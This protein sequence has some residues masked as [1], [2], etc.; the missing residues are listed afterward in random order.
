MTT[1]TESTDTKEAEKA[2]KAK[3]KAV[4]LL[5]KERESLMQ[6]L[7]TAIVAEAWAKQAATQAFVGT[8]RERLKTLE[9]DMHRELDNGEK[10]LSSA[11]QSKYQGRRQ[12]LQAILL[13]FDNASVGAAQAVN[14]IREW[15]S[16]ESDRE[17]M[18]YA[19]PTWGD[20]WLAEANRRLHEP[21]KAGGKK[22]KA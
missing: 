2:A 19:P 21:E 20:D 6:K 13:M 12:E 5:A 1:A 8:L 7:L 3:E 11:D 10:P 14:N 15:E 9:E 18:F 22:T 16:Q 4:S 17:P